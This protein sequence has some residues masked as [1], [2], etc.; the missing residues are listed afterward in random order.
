MRSS[1]PRNLL[2]LL[3]T[4]CVRLSSLST[5]TSATAFQLRRACSQPVPTSQCSSNKRVIKPPSIISSQ[6]WASRPVWNRA[7]LNTLRC[8]VGCTIGDF[9]AM[10]YLQASHPE[11]GTGKIM[12]ISSTWQSARRIGIFILADI[13][14]WSA[15]LPH[16]YYLKPLFFA[17][18]A[19]DLA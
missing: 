3:P 12:A 9:S 18:V 6:F 5:R 17:S 2:R 14:Q 19:I 4:N 1:T 13:I 16:L 15:A 10:W 11:L 8:L 7:A